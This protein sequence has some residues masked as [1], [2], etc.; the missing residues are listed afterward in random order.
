MKRKKLGL[1]HTSATLVPVF[2]AL[3]KEKL[4]NVD[5]FKQQIE[6]F[7]EFLV[8]SAMDPAAVAAQGKDIDFL[9]ALGEVFSLVVYGQLLIEYRNLD[10]AELS[11]DLLDQIFDETR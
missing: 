5:V 9:L 7:K 6:V 11:N 1:V 4:P 2:A 10:A 8:A 3:C